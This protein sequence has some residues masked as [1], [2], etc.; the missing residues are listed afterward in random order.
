[1]NTNKLDYAPGDRLYIFSYGS[2]GPGSYV[3]GEVK[4]VT[5]SGQIVVTCNGRERRFMPSGREVGSDRYHVDYIEP[6]AKAHDRA[7]VIRAAVARQEVKNETRA[8]L[9]ALSRLDAIHQQTELIT[10]L[11][12]LA[13][14]L[15]VGEA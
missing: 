5:P 10:R 13:D 7:G 14:K 8:E 3:V 12:A 9:E 1:M 11:R 2:W 4:K 6:K 15:A